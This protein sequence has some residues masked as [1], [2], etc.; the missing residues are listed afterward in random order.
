LD[1]FLLGGFIPITRIHVPEN[2]AVAELSRGLQY[3]FG[4]YALGRAEK[5]GVYTYG[6]KRFFRF[7]HF[8]IE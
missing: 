5:I 7:S 1:D 4:A 8:L 6:I 3:R 2:Y